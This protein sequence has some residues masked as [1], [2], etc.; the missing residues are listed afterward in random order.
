VY[1]LLPLLRSRICTTLTRLGTTNDTVRPCLRAEASETVEAARTKAT[2]ALTDVFV[3]A[4]LC[5]FP[6]EPAPLPP[7]V[8]FE[9]VL[10]TLAAT[11][12]MFAFAPVLTS[13]TANTGVTVSRLLARPTSEAAG[14]ETVQLPSDAGVTDTGVVVFFPSLADTETPVA[15]GCATPDTVRSAPLPIVVGALVIAFRAHGAI[16]LQP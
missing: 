7:A 8:A 14:I 6:D 1:V 2:R 10:V 5:P 16:E 12:A 13:G 15:R 9:S 4:V 11:P 3:E